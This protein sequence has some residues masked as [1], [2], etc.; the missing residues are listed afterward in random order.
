MRTQLL[1]LLLSAQIIGSCQYSQDS[2]FTLE[3]NLEG[4]SL[5][6]PRPP[7]T[8][9]L[10][11]SIDGGQTW[12]DISADLPENADLNC[13]LVHKG[14]MLLGSG[15]GLYRKTASSK[16]QKDYTLNGE[17]TGIYPTK[18]GLYASTVKDGLCQNI[19]GEIWA[20]MFKNF[21]DQRF[22]TL[23]EAADK[24]LF[25]GCDNGMF[26]SVDRG[27]T[28]KHVYSNG[29]VIEMAESNGVLICTNEQ[30]ILR[31]TDGGEHWEVV[32]SEGGVGINVEVIEGGF[33]AITYNAESETRRVR[34]S[35]DGGKTW[36]AIDEG[37][38]P[39][40]NIA[41]IKQVGDYFYC[42]HPNGVFRSA[43]RG[44]TWKLLLPAIKNKVYNLS[45]SG[46]VIYAVPQN[47]GC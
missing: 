7:M 46:N 26:K 19:S 16:W 4:Q 18:D 38:P 17:I 20:P 6:T 34:I 36:Q 8:N 35:E 23:F 40:A 12:Q 42:G 5:A 22:R 10:F 47:Q 3:A 31:S 1:A 27:K 44:K 37:L 11:Q 14:E 28:W 9:L 32:I 45:V 25:Y 29:W 15:D 13:F 24:S 41:S 21:E 33:A 30:G 39:S 43:D 2:S